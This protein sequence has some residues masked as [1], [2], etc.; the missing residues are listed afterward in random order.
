MLD[1]YSEPVRVT[2][3]L[4]FTTIAVGDE[5][6]CALTVDG[7]TYCWGSNRYDQLGNAAATETC[8]KGPGAYSC[9]STPVRVPDVPRFESVVAT[10]WGTCGLDESL[11][12]FS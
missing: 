1:F 5:H 6:T 11:M 7:E 4:K 8:G 9:S 10:R 3:T 2:D 12:R